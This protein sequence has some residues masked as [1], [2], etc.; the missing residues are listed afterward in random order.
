MGKENHAVITFKSTHHAI[1]GEDK[2]GQYKIDFRIIPT[3]REITE[4]CGIAIKFSSKDLVAIEEIIRKEEI[5]IDEIFI[6]KK[7]DNKI[8]LEKT[9]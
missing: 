9:R 4:S 5:Q 1:Q 2:I 7:I 3:P 8:K 6:Y